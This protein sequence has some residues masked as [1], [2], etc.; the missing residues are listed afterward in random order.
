M[1][2]QILLLLLFMINI[3][4]FETMY[5]PWI[6]IYIYYKTEDEA[7]EEATW[8]NAEKPRDTF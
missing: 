5:P 1:T 2:Y 6:K 8:Q 3:L 4:F 7:P